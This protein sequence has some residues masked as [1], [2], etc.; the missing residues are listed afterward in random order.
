MQGVQGMQA[1]NAQAGLY[2]AQAG[3]DRQQAGARIAADDYRANALIS[4]G[5]A[6]AAASGVDPGS[7]SAKIVSQQNASMAML[8]DMYS[9]YSGELAAHSDMAQAAFARFEGKQKL[10]GG[11]GKAV[12]TALTI[13]GTPTA[14][15]GLGLG[16]S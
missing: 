8:N 3:L 11:I 2:E 5:T 7:G 10:I 15:G 1:G 12:G 9:R 4:A 16:F 14:A 6:N 13:G